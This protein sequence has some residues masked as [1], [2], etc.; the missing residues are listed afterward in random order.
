MVVM[1]QGR[2]TCSESEDEG[3]GLSLLGSLCPG[4]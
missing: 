3:S 2:Q 1:E 4:L